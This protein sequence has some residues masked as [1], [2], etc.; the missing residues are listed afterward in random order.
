MVG[1]YAIL[2]PLSAPFKPLFYLRFPLFQLSYHPHFH[3][4]FPG[5]DDFTMA[6][7]LCLLGTEYV[8]KD[9]FGFDLKLRGGPLCIWLSE[10]AFK[11][12]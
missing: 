1:C 2:V 8:W 12:V 3:L 6:K 11:C 9:A 5:A 10:G 4:S 7:H